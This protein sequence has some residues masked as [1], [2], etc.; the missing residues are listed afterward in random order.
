[1]C[2]TA[3]DAKLYGNKYVLY[4]AGRQA[5][6]ATTILKLISKIIFIRF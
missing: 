5:G 1:M 4:V 3:L 6:T 2:D